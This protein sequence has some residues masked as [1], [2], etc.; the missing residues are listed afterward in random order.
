MDTVQSGRIG[1]ISQPGPI[2]VALSLPVQV[3]QS[4][5][6]AACARGVWLNGRCLNEFT[7][8]EDEA[9]QVLPTVH[10]NEVAEEDLMF[11]A[12]DQDVLQSGSATAWLEDKASDQDQ[13]WCKPPALSQAIK[14]KHQVVLLGIGRWG[15][16]GG[17]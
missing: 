12:D 7:V 4:C 13:L 15:W 10:T 11:F 8:D 3:C 6:L 5:H 9:G 17:S 1:F 2:N 16:R 14:V